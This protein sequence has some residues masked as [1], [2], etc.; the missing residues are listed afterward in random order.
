MSTYMEDMPSDSD[1]ELEVDEQVKAVKKRGWGVYLSEK[2][3]HTEA[4]FVKG[5]VEAVD[6]VIFAKSKKIADTTSLR[7][8]TLLRK[9]RDLLLSR[10]AKY[11]GAPLSSKT[12]KRA[13]ALRVIA[14]LDNDGDYMAKLNQPGSAV[15]QDTQIHVETTSGS[16]KLYRG[17]AKAVSRINV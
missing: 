1:D 4:L 16:T 8:S 12:T 14:R 15:E 5:S 13:E 9:A 6:P 11:E 10:A 2:N 3:R 7:L 17:L